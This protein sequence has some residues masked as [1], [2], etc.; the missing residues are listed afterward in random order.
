M[1]EPRGDVLSFLQQ[2]HIPYPVGLDE[3]GSISGRYQVN[4]L[5]VSFLIDRHGTVQSVR[6]GVVDSAYR[7]TQ[8]RPLL[9]E[10]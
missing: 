2:L 9:S 3:S 10:Q 8:V 4:V 6:I 5:P 1:E 7:M